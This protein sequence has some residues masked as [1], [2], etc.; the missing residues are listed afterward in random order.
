[1]AESISK[2][3]KLRFTSDIADNHPKNRLP[4]LDVETWIEEQ[5]DGTQ[6]LMHSFYEKQMASP[7]VFHKRSAYNV[8]AKIVT[9][10]EE[11]R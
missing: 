5:K 9:L 2:G 11:V 7:I 4:M 8:K 1:M 10:S 6:I 3:V